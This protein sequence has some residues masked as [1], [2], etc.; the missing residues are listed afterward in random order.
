MDVER[1]KKQKTTTPL[2]LR[3]SILIQS[4][5]GFSVAMQ[6]EEGFEVCCIS[7]PYPMKTD[8]YNAFRKLIGIIYMRLYT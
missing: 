7:S 3:S 1:K 5:G 8:K 6:R 2:V 4:C